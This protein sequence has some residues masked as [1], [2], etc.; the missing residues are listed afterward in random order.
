MKIQFPDRVQAFLDANDDVTVAHV[1]MPDGKVRVV[2]VP[3]L[4]GEENSQV[5]SDLIQRIIEK[6]DEGADNKTEDDLP[7]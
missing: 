3:A 6:Q 7:F 4:W 5:V 2:L 1:I